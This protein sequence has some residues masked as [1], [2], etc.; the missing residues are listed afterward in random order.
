MWL[1][2]IR[3]G[4]SL[5]CRCRRITWL[6]AHVTS[7]HNLVCESLTV[8][9]AADLDRPDIAILRVVCSPCAGGGL[10]RLGSP[11]LRVCHL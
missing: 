4:K 11:P 2:F 1:Y 7:V 6:L 3:I 8:Q 9:R 5:A 10:R